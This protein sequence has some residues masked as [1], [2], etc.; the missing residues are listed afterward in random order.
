MYARVI[1]EDDDQ[2]QLMAKERC[3]Q[4]LMARY[5]TMLTMHG[6]ALPQIYSKVHCG[7]PG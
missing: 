4:S 3:E 2:S 7:M 1:Q 6:A 5:G